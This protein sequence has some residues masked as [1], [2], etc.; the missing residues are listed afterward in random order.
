MELDEFKK[1]IDP[2]IFSGVY[3][4]EKEKEEILNVLKWFINSKELKERNIEIPKGI[5]LYGDPGC[6]KSLIIRKII[7]GINVQ[8]YI[9]K[10]DGDNVAK[11]LQETFDKA[12][13]FGKCIIVI[14]ELDLL[15][16]V[17]I[18]INFIKCYI[19]HNLHVYAKMVFSLVFYKL[20]M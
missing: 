3:G 19:I 11:E 5:I 16:V 1:E 2:N 8:T 12:R 4:L 13:K 18:S 9:V 15:N 7:Q 10:G 6:G 14:D 20:Q 17:L